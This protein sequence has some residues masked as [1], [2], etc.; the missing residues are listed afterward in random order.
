M[1]FQEKKN[2]QLEPMMPG[3]FALRSQDIEPS[4]FDAEAFSVSKRINF[5]SQ[6]AGSDDSFLGYPILKS[7]A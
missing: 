2:K 6:G 3:K 5:K 7:K 4:F 1:G